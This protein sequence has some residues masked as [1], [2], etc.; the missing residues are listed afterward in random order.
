MGF[1]ELITCT[2]IKVLQSWFK[3]GLVYIN[4][5]METFDTWFGEVSNKTKYKKYHTVRT[6]PK[7]N[8][9]NR[10]KFQNPIEIIVERDKINTP[11]THNQSLSFIGTGISIKSGRVKLDL[12]APTSLLS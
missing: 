7:S 5:N 2:M 1:T 3:D 4:D 6:V 9:N 8:R 11:N 12:L 10:R